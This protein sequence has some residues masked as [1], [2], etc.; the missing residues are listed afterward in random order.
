[1]WECDEAAS[2]AEGDG[3]KGPVDER[4][5]ELSSLGVLVIGLG[6]EKRNVK[7]GAKYR[8]VSWYN[9]EAFGRKRCWEKTKFAVKAS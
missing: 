1:M 4:H 8:R 5:G 3:D 6:G 2:M 7:R 9:E